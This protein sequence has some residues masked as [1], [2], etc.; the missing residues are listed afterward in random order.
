MYY[1]GY[2][3]MIILSNNCNI[4]LK[5]NR[6]ILFNNQLYYSKYLSTNHIILL[7]YII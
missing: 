1:I 4:D 7:S 3:M 5:S 6:K 2:D